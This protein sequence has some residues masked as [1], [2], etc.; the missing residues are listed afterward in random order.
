[1]SIRT[2]LQ[3]TKAVL[4]GA[5]NFPK[6]KELHTLE[7]VATNIKELNRVFGDKRILGLFSNN[8][9]SLYNTPDNTKIKEELA[10]AAEAA[11]DTLIFYYAGHIILRR[12]QLYL[13]TVNSSKQ[14]VHVNAI[15]LAE[16][17]NI[18]RENESATKILI[19]D[20][21]YQIA[22]ANP[23]NSVQQLVKDEFGKFEDSLKTAYV[24]T[25]SPET[26]SESFKIESPSAFT[27][28]FIKLLETGSKK[29]ADELSLNDIFDG[30]SEKMKAGNQLPPMR[31]EKSAYRNRGFA[32]NLKFIEYKKFKTEGDTFFT[33]ENFGEAL[34]L[35]QYAAKLYNNDGDLN[36]KIDFINFVSE[37]NK[38]FSKLDYES[39]RQNYQYAHQLFGH[40]SI[41]NKIDTSV[42][43]MA[44]EHFRNEHFEKAKE[45]YAFLMN[46]FPENEIF[47]ER[48]EKCEDEILLNELMDEADKLFF[49]ERY[50]EASELYQR[51]IEIEPDRRTIR[52][53]EECDFLLSKE[54]SL[55]ERLELEMA[56]K[57][58]IDI[59]SIVNE[60]VA[61]REA[62]LRK[63]LE[64]KLRVS[65]KQ[66]VSEELEKQIWDKVTLYDAVD[67]YRFYLELF[68]QGAFKAKATEKKTDLEMSIQKN[69]HPTEQV[70]QETANQNMLPTDNNE[71]AEKDIEKVIA[72]EATVAL[73]IPIFEE[74][75]V[76]DRIGLFDDLLG[77][78]DDIII[79]KEENNHVF[80]VA[81]FQMPVFEA[82]YSTKASQIENVQPVSL[83]VGEPPQQKIS[84]EELWAE[85]TNKNS[86]QGF[87]HYIEQTVDSNHIADAYYYI[88]KI[89]N[90]Q[91]QEEEAAKITTAK[92][93][94]KPTA[95][96]KA[97]MSRIQVDT[98]PSIDL[99]SDNQDDLLWQEARKTDTVSAYYNYLNDANTKK[100]REDAKKRISTLNELEKLNE[101]REWEH[102]TTLDTIEAYKQYLKKYPFGNYYA[103]ARF[104]ITKLESEMQA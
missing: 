63:V 11:T 79:S 26:T 92:A 37:G 65:I 87:M 58:N 54:K 4:M 81:S 47:R 17:A 67:F 49:Q 85:A 94:A 102:A 14:Q 84:E 73:E 64:V 3:S 22:D 1:M 18:I 30:I 103:K 8:I 20:C 101:Q 96:E 98:T 59:K 86:I 72:Q 68:P 55:R 62:N 88:S 53:K 40:Q 104:R 78:D 23:T 60:E 76:E 70:A 43:R 77:D 38:H 9:I 75:K 39:A 15:S 41:K 13:T 36:N 51:A 69:T 45:N 97:E 31:G 66:E 42:E 5:G 100:H 83:K 21:T 71:Q 10:V 34:P 24:I 27:N 56:N 48:F 28:H 99:S 33:K 46:S 95:E 89:R 52:R 32:S 6:D 80:D 25:S 82:S 90:A 29:E 74:I 12:G 44:E 7:N 50:G 93:Q 19:F 2:N 16:L 57:Q 91:A 35:Y 61:K